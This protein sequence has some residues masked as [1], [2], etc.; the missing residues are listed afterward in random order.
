MEQG[1]Y[2][3]DSEILS[4]IIRKNQERRKRMVDLNE[5]MTAL[6]ITFRMLLKIT[7]YWIRNSQIENSIAARITVG[8]AYFVDNHES[9]YPVNKV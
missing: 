9:I 6:N 7:E 3:N 4:D 8:A 2:A 5:T 1:F